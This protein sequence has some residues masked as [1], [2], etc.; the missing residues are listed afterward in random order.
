MKHTIRKLVTAMLVSATFAAAAQTGPVKVA[1]IMEL[2]GSGATPGTNFNNG[3][4]L[5]VK[6][7][8]ATG[9]IL[10]RQVDYQP[11]D[12]QTNP[13]VAKAL[14]QKAVD[15]GAYVV[16]GPIHSGSALVAMSVMQDAEVTEITGGEAA[17]ITEKG[18][19]Y[20]FRSSFTQAIT[21]PKVARYFKDYVKA[22]TV[23]IVYS[24]NDN[25]KG[26]RDYFAK[27]LDAVGIKLVADIP[28][29]PQQV[30]FSAAAIKAKQSGA[31]ALFLYTLEEE[32]AHM[33][34]E[35]RKQGYDKPIVGESQSLSNKTLELAGDAANGMVGHVGI[36]ID[37]PDPRIQAFAARYRKEYGTNSDQNGMKGYITMYVV[38]AMTEKI[39]KF[40]SKALAAAMHGANISAAQNPGVLMDIGFDKNGDIVRGSF[41]VKIENGKQVVTGTLPPESR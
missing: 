34:R 19:P 2:S 38:K 5:A 7:I 26:G 10:G 25:G 8:N 30:D 11:V 27:A 4:K 14:A 29:D 33:I 22:K 35:L 17:S 40:D 39:G 13:A 31:D 24:N 41:L 36:S 18:N 28:T 15:D 1:G 32:S 6:E 37:S 9:G 16:L 12:T 3:V 23:A 21:M 20:I